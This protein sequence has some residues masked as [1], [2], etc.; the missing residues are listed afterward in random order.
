MQDSRKLLSI[1]L[2]SLSFTVASSGMAEQQRMPALESNNCV[3]SGKLRGDPAN[4][5]A[6]HVEHCAACHGMTGAADVVVMHMDETPR[7]QSDPTYMKQLP[8]EYL[9]LAICKGGEGIG[10]SYVMSPWGDFFTDQEIRDLIAWVRSFSG[11]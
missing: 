5:K 1:C 2:L 7:D 6:L 8:D 3:P 11:T 4:G 9:Y 10:K